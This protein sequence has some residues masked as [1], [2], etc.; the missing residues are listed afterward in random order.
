MFDPEMIS[1]LAGILH[2]LSCT[3]THAT[4][5]EELLQRDANPEICYFYLEES[6]YDSDRPSHLEWESIATKLCTDNELTPEDILRFLPILL[7][8]RQKIENILQK[9]PNAEELC[10]LVLFS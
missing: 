1:R 9:A 5:M 10:R 8:C 7:E 6:L 3:K 2:T 4:K